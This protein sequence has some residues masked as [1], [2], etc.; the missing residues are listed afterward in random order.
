MAQSR[1]EIARIDL[2][3]VEQ[4]SWKGAAELAKQVLSL[5]DLLDIPH[6]RAE[7]AR[8]GARELD[9]ILRVATALWAG[10]GEVLPALRLDW[11]ERL[12]QFDAPFDLRRLSSL[13]RWE[14]I[15]VARPAGAPGAGRL[16]VPAGRPRR[17]GGRG[18]DQ[19]PGAG[20][21]APGEPRAGGP[22][23]GRYTW[24][25]TPRSGRAASCRWSSISRG[26][27]SACT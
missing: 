19:R 15:E 1:A 2:A 6:G 9:E 17:A 26:C 22:D 25:R 24:P 20:L 12:S 5:G 11:V 4:Q 21:P 10:F 8:L 7:V 16:A 27:G 23:R 13:P 3:A 18:A 14:E